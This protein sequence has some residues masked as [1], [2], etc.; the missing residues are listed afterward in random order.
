[1]AKSKLMAIRVYEY[2]CG[3]GQIE[4]LGPAI[5]QMRCRTEFWNRLVEIDNDVRARMD[6]WL[7][8]G[9]RET[10]LDS[11]REK[12]RE[13]IRTGSS[14][15][16][17]EDDANNDQKSIRMHEL[18]AAIRLKLDEV[19][20]IRKEN[21]A[22]HRAQLRE[23]DDER[24]RRIAEAQT[25]TGLYYANRDEIRHTYEL[26]RAQAMRQGRHLRPQSWDETG[27][28][29]VQFQ[30]GGLPVPKAFLKNGRLQIDPVADAAWGSPRSLRRRLTQTRIRIRVNANEDRSPVWISVPAVLHRPLPADGM[31]RAVSFIRE[32]VGLSWRYRV[33]FTVL[34][35]SPNT[36]SLDNAVGV[37]LGWRLTSKGL[38]VA[39][40]TDEDGQMGELV[41]PTTDLCEFK[42]IGSLQATIIAALKKTQALVSAFIAR[43][44]MPDDLRHSAEEALRSLSPRAFIGLFEEWKRHRFAGDRY[45]FTKLRNWYKQHVHLWTWQ[46]NLRDQLLRRRRELYRRF[47]ANL[48]AR[49][50]KIFVNDFQLRNVTVRLIASDPVVIQGQRQHR[51][52]AGISVL[53]QILQSACEKR[54]AFFKRVKFKG[55][56]KSCHVCGA[57]DDWNPR[58]SLTHTCSK[59]GQS[60]DQ[61]YNAAMHALKHGRAA[62]NVPVGKR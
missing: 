13:V 32:R 58:T 2:G 57:I 27:R 25:S 20:K 35:T 19:K 46:A 15:P 28:I 51:F 30:R 48:S 54:G 61:D 4:G 39:Y 44:P 40:W 29:K 22:R 9:E 34:E 12:L 56:T 10:E 26:A 18:R 60:W 8:A 38:R 41:L 62:P 5:D 17:A 1:M 52:I 16:S 53:C 37:D 6:A 21:A 36:S 43:H 59:C 42:R 33:L 24:K 23:L 7:F 45:V 11:L 3:R 50:G 55:A 14:E 49:Y 47:A 31:I